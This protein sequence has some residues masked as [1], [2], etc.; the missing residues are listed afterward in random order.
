MSIFEREIQRYTKKGLANIIVAIAI[1]GSYVYYA[2]QFALRVWPTVYGYLEKYEPWQYSLAIA[3]IWHIICVVSANLLTWLFYNLKLSFI[4]QY[5]IQK[6][7]RWPWI[8][9]DSKAWHS[10][11][12]KALLNYA[13]NGFV[14]LPLMVFVSLAGS[15]WQPPY[16][17]DQPSLEKI[18]SSPWKF[19]FLE[20]FCLLCEDFAFHVMHRLMHKWKFL[21]QTVHKIHHQYTQPVGFSAEYSHPL[22][23][24]LT[25]VVPSSL[26]LLILGP[27]NVHLATVLLGAVLRTFEVVDAHSG[28]DFPWSPFRV[29]P[30]SVSASYHD[31]HHSE[32]SGGN[33]SGVFTIWDTIFG[34]NEHFYEKEEAKLK[35]K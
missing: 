35:L 6:D 8:E 22:E 12:R 32:F 33:Y 13:L 7:S 31:Y 24:I 20:I 29:L 26:P 4:E 10:E 18:L 34:G 16:S 2:P 11:V 23:Y 30:F 3:T 28:Y 5:K 27:S 15:N 1:M 19:L 17:V 9:K 25:G 14:T 21:Y